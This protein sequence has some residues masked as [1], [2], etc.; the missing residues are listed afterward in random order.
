MV[1][2][3]AITGKP[4]PQ[5]D[6]ALGVRGP[7]S[8]VQQDGQ[9]F[10]KGPGGQLLG[11]LGGEGVFKPQ[12]ID[13]KGSVIVDDNHFTTG[14]G[15]D[16]LRGEGRPT[17]IWTNGGASTFE[18]RTVGDYDANDVGI[19]EGC[20]QN[21]PIGSRFPGIDRSIKGIQVVYFE[22]I[23]S[24]DQDNNDVVFGMRENVGGT[25]GPGGSTF[26]TAESLVFPGLYD[27]AA[28]A[29][30]VMATCGDVPS[31]GFDAGRNEHGIIIDNPGTAPHLGGTAGPGGSTYMT[32]TFEPAAGM[33]SFGKSLNPVAELGANSGPGG[34][35]YMSGKF[36]E[37]SGQMISPL[38]GGDGCAF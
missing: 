1:T 9:T 34:T 12:D 31:P 25:A 19:Q 21:V 28:Y 4:A 8:L 2:F 30:S 37:N 17:K 23:R 3:D 32:E 10:Y 33:D 24:G 5:G 18:D 15:G 20:G 29:G 22:D 35:S 6:L 7:L 13:T 16:S 26:M 14:G 36:S 38:S 27:L 11:P